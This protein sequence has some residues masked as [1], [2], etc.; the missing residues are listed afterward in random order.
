MPIQEFENPVE[1]F[2]TW[3]DEAR[4]CEAIDDPTAM[5]L[6]TASREGLP[7]VRMVLLK[8]YDDQGFVFYTNLGSPKAVQLQENGH[9]ALCFYWMP[10][11]KQV[12]IRGRVIPVTSEAADAYFNSRDRKSKIGAWASKQ[13]QPLESRFH[14]EKR[15]AV[16]AARFGL[17]RVP[18]PEFWSG[19]RLIPREIE[20]WLG[21]PFRLH[22]RLQYSHDGALWTRKRLFP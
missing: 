22:D 1:L 4:R 9:A 12:R 11:E 15:V 20:F 16:F 5:A 8:G 6:A 13:S 10:L 21:Q 17:G 2:S 14:L 7:D 3:F 19:F 18:R